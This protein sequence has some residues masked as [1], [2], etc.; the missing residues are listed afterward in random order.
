MLSPSMFDDLNF[1]LLKCFEYDVFVQNWKTENSI[2]T[3]VDSHN[4]TSKNYSWEVNLTRLIS[5]NNSITLTWRV[6]T[7]SNFEHVGLLWI[8]NRSTIIN[9]SRFL[10]TSVSNKV[11]NYSRSKNIIKR[12]RLLFPPLYTCTS[13]ICAH[14]N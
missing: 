12:F 3:T 8:W 6:Y 14:R 5:A 9:H 10:G 11:K 4:T 13:A 2:P 7:Y 1:F